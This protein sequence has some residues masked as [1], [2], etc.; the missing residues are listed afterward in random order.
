[1][2]LVVVQA[3]EADRVSEGLR[4]GLG[5]GLRGDEVA[6]LLTGPAARFATPDAGDARIERALRTLAE[7]GRPARVVAEHEVDDWVARARAV[8]VWTSGGGN[9]RRL[10][11]GPRT[12]YFEPGAPIDAGDLVAQIFGSDGPIVL[13]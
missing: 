12:L 7:L 2:I 5:L 6:V 9:T 10:S 8:E 11:L 4:A 1:L 13:L 3:A